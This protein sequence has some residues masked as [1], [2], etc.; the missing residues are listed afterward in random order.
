MK[1][2][3]AAPQTIDQYIADF[4][5]DIQKI[6]QK[7]RATIRKAAPGA[8]EAI[9]YQM[10]TFVLNGNLVHFAAFKHHIGFY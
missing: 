4:P 8:A 5:E 1:T 10:P 6:L 3:Q 7:I 2:N 9:K